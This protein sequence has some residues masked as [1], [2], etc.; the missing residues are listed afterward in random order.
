MERERVS[1]SETSRRLYRDIRLSPGAMRCLVGGAP[2]RS[3]P[4][5][6]VSA[7]GRRSFSPDCGEL[8]AG[9]QVELPEPALERA[10]VGVHVGHFGDRES[11]QIDAEGG[12]EAAHARAATAHQPGLVAFGPRRAGVVE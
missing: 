6:W 3:A 8:E 7:A 1:R 4:A 2:A 10:V 9:L 12:A 11:E 5:A